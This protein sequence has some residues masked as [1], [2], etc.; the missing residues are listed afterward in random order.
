MGIERIDQPLFF[1][2]CDK[3]QRAYE[4]VQALNED[5]AIRF[6]QHDGWRVVD[7]VCTCKTCVALEKVPPK[8]EG[9]A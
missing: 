6:A 7:K 3:C 9:G 5:A 1:C 4:G 2:R 8:T